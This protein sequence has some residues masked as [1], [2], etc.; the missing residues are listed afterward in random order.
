MSFDEMWTTI[1]FMRNKSNEITFPKLRYISTYVRTL[2][3][4][5]AEAERS[6]SIIPDAQTIKRNALG[7]DTVYVQWNLLKEK[8]ISCHTLVVN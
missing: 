6:F 2:P 7:N 5:N 4:S 8:V 1:S 3:H